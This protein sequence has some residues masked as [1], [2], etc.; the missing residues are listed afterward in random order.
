MGQSEFDQVF[1]TDAQISDKAEQDL[2][3][4]VREVNILLLAGLVLSAIS[5]IGSWLYFS[6]SISSRLKRLMNNI[7]VLGEQ[8]AESLSVGGSDEITSLDQAI[9]V[10]SKKLIEAQQFQAQT[11][12]IVVDELEIPLR[13]AGASFL[14]LRQSGIESLSPAAGTSEHIGL[15]R[16]DYKLVGPGKNANRKDS[17]GSCRFESG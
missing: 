10:T 8:H 14:M 15:N 1:G 3:N 9:Q 2:Q 4:S 12:R 13:K 7:S 16:H 6:S 5:S 11:I 17:C